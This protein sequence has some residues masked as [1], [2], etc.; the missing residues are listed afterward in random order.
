MSDSSPSIRATDCC[1]DQGRIGEV[2]HGRRAAAV[3]RRLKPGEGS[4]WS[5]R[6]LRLSMHARLV[7]FAS[8][9]VEAYGDLVISGWWVDVEALTGIPSVNEPLAVHPDVRVHVSAAGAE[10]SA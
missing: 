5:T 3:D 2:R 7:L 8:E 4:R 1:Q 9:V 6:S 10:P